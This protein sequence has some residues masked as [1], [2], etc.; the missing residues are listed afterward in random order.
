[1]LKILVFVSKSDVFKTGRMGY[2]IVNSDIVLLFLRM[3]FYYDIVRK[4]TDRANGQIGMETPCGENGR[5]RGKRSKYD[6][7]RRSRALKGGGGPVGVQVNY[8]TRNTARIR[9]LSPTE[10]GPRGSFF[11]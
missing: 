8:S 4:S 3:P 5:E 6:V 9:A 7:P 1:M 10:F 2:G 11:P